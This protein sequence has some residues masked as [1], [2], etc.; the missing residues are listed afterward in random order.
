MADPAD[1]L[2]KFFTQKSQGGEPLSQEEAL[3][4]QSQ[5]DAGSLSQPIIR[6]DDDSCSVICH[7]PVDNCFLS[8]AVAGPRTYDPE[9]VLKKYQ[10]FYTQPTKPQVPAEDTVRPSSRPTLPILDSHRVLTP[11]LKMF[12]PSETEV[13]Y[14]EKITV[15]EEPVKASNSMPIEQPSGLS[16]TASAIMA[17]LGSNHPTHRECKEVEAS[18]I[19]ITVLPVDALEET[20]FSFTQDSTASQTEALVKPFLVDMPGDGEAQPKRTRRRISV[21]ELVPLPSTQPPVLTPQKIPSPP[22]PVFEFSL[23][24]TE[25][26]ADDELRRQAK[27]LSDSQIPEFSFH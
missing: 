2:H 22:L 4:V 8:Q 14:Q 16:K 7:N 19:E 21:E 5:L 17:V 25:P 23:P 9:E 12:K 1:L 18:M 20:P 6:N 26:L 15:V 24:V 13:E 10:H 11:V 3:W 27:E